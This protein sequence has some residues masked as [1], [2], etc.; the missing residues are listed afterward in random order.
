MLI[1]NTGVYGCSSTIRENTTFSLTTFPSKYSSPVNCVY[2]LI[3][4]MIGYKVKI[5]LLYLDIQ[6][7]EC[8]TEKIEIYDGKKLIPQKKM[9]EICNGST[10]ET[11]FISSGRHMRIRYI[12]NTLNT[13][14]G[15]HASVKF[16]L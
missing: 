10:N 14:Q 6:D 1:Y 9:T 12:G 16:I 13:Y 7:A 3:A 2:S 5:T 15:F 11:E 4:P 8:S